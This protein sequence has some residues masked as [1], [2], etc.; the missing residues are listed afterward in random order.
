MWFWFA[1]VHQSEKLDLFD[2]V[3]TCHR[4][5]LAVL[6]QSPANRG[7]FQGRADRQAECCHHVGTGLHFLAR[8]VHCQ[9]PDRLYTDW[10]GDVGYGAVKD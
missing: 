10:R 6:L 8:G 4:R 1:Q 2:P 5:F 9:V 7:S 3:R